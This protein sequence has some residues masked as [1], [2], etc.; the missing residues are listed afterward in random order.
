VVS[1]R[2]KSWE[3]FLGDTKGASAYLLC[4]RALWKF[5]MEGVTERTT[6]ELKKAIATSPYVL[7]YLLGTKTS[8][9]RDC[10]S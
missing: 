1:L 6:T 10:P 9:R 8:W 5:H 2:N 3:S 7:V 4:T